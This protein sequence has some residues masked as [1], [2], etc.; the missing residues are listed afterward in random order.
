MTDFVFYFD[1]GWH[2]IISL[3]AAD[4]L[5]F[6]LAL[7]AIYLFHDWKKL[8]ILVTAFTVGHSCTLALSVYDILRI[9]GKWVEFLI[10]VT[11]I[12]TAIFN[13][14]QK[15]FNPSSLRLNYFLALFF[16]LI[17]GMGFANA[18]RFMLAKS[19]G[20]GLP[21]FSFNLGLEAGQILVVFLILLTSFF[22]VNKSGLQRKLWV[23]SLSLIALLPALYMAV[24]RWPS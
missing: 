24:D 22:I 2:H 14:M 4:H 17:H 6:I 11:I 15:N 21:L 20:I 16:G 1:L 8:L 10:P 7:S 9:N 13:L 23:R 12:A 3:E 19:Q 18:I 5:L